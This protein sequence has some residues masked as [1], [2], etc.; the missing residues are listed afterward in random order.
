MK[1]IILIVIA[2]VCAVMMI[3]G[4]FNALR[5][6]LSYRESRGI[7]EELEQ[8]L[9]F[10]PAGDDQTS[11]EQEAFFGEEYF[12]LP[13]HI[14]L[15]EVDFDALREI[16]P[17]VVAWIILE[18]TPINYPVVQGADNDFYLHHLFDGRRNPSGAI[19][20]DSY[21]SPGFTDFH[22]IIYGHHMRDGSMFAAI[23]NY[24]NEGFFE[25][26]PWVFLLTPERNYVIKLSTG[27]LADPST[28]HTWEIVF[29]DDMEK[30]VWIEERQSKSDFDS[31]VEILPSHRIVTLST[32]SNAFFDARYVISGRLMPIRQ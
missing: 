2:L 3:V 32:C 28:M 11:E 25:E 23:E 29:E 22:T 9:T 31:G 16:N 13:D 21:N 19:F 15:P 8:H 10:T 1:R 14:V 5:I 27:H 30:S 4:G 7:Y 20:V 24:R 6:M 17:N 26:H 18:G 12:I